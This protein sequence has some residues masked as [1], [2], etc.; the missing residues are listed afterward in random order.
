MMHKHWTGGLFLLGIMHTSC[1]GA[2]LQDKGPFLIILRALHPIGFGTN[3][4]AAPRCIVM[5]TKTRDVLS[6]ALYL[7]DATSC[8]THMIVQDGLDLTTQGLEKKAVLASLTGFV[9]SLLSIVL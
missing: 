2:V 1:G 7:A 4:F 5:Q 6:L 8:T 9:V 3:P